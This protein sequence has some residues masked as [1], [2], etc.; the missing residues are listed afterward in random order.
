M[1]VLNE[2]MF[3]KK[4]KKVCTT[5]WL[6][7]DDACLSLTNSLEEIHNTFSL[8]YNVTLLKNQLLGMK[9]KEFFDD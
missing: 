5:H 9:L 1:G 4:T 8:I 3:K 2:G 6:T 7:R